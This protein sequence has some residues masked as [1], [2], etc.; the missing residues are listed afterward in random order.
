LAGSCGLKTERK[1]T[2][3]SRKWK[4]PHKFINAD[5]V[6]FL[7]WFTPLEE[8][9]E[10]KN[11][12]PITGEGSMQERANDYQLRILHSIDL[13]DI[14]KLLEDKGCVEIH[15]KENHIRYRTQGILRL[16]DEISPRIG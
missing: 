4:I 12:R 1:R 9:G 2:E 16:L 8:K 10:S 14:L 7:S 11:Q 6:D 3:E 13:G 15:K 5:F